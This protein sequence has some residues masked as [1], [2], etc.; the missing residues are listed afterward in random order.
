MPA[1]PVYPPSD[2]VWRLL[3]LTALLTACLYV[4]LVQTS[5]NDFWLQA[6]IGEI[7]L[8]ERAVPGTLLF[9]F[10]E[11][12]TQV[13]HAH[14]WLASIVF[15]GMLSLLGEDGLPYATA[16]LGTTFLLLVIRLAYLRSNANLGLSL[17]CGLI[18]L[19]VENYRHAL[20]PELF[21][22]LLLPVYWV[23]LEQFRSK[24]DWKKAALALV[25]V[26]LWANI[27]GSFVLAP[28]MA[29]IYAL[30][31]QLD[32]M[33][34]S[35]TLRLVPKPTAIAFAALG[36]AS[37]FA[38]LLNPSGSELLS[39]VFHFSNDAD[40]SHLIAEWEPTLSYKWIH[41]PGFWL[42]ACAWLVMAAL[43]AMRHKRASAVDLLFFLF[44]SLLAAKAIRFPVYLGVVAAFTVAG[45][46]P[47]G[48]K[49]I[50]W[51]RGL[52]GLVLCL[53][54][55]ALTASLLFGNAFGVYPYTP[56]FSKFSTA[57]VQA[58]GDPSRSGNVLNSFS[59][60]SELVYRA[61]PRLRPSV[62]ARIDSYGTE[63]VKYQIA[64]LSDDALFAEFVDRYAVRFLLLDSVAFFDFQQGNAWRSGQW[65]L[66]LGDKNA[67]LLERSGG[68]DFAGKMQ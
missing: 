42:A 34:A 46:A 17:L 30:G 28:A 7:T 9:P 45:Q 3:A 8:S 51:Q 12:S 22:L 6:K 52:H 54:A 31:I 15:H 24:P 36:A 21:S 62:D 29:G 5:G 4:S 32:A 61:Y 65:R 11:V 53:S 43:L 63:Y 26:V 48:C 58:L 40:L 2:R 44:F 39:F 67:A 13:F 16:L 41:I 68:D 35:G 14:E 56:G 18:A 1:P 27:H 60:G 49:E 33:R 38:C 19:S 55:L 20:R 59:L 23:V 47:A 50:R 25:L 37:V 57:M 10:T 64:V 66:V